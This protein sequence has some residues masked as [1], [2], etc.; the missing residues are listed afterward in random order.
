MRGRGC[1]KER[2]GGTER[3]RYRDKEREGWERKR[4]RE[5]KTEGE[6]KEERERG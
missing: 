4:R 3:R 5:I 6:T 2:L 1:K